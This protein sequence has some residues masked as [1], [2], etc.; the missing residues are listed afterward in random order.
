MGIN[1]PNDYMSKAQVAF[2]VVNIGET[3]ITV[4]NWVFPW[5]TKCGYVLHFLGFYTVCRWYEYFYFIFSHDAQF[6]K[7]SPPLP[8]SPPSPTSSCHHYYWEC[9]NLL[10]HMA[11]WWLPLMHYS[12]YYYYSGFLNEETEA[13]RV[14]HLPKFTQSVHVPELSLLNIVS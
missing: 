12:R 13:Q 2:K 3:S 6:I 1:L 5:T 9:D 4:F 8:P 10:T 7:S 11:H 14:S